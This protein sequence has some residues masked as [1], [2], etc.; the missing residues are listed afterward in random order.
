MPGLKKGCEKHP[1]TGRKKGGLNKR[2]EEA[3]ALAER[4]GFNP[5]ELLAHFAMGNWE[6]LG[7]P[8]PTKTIVT[9]E[10]SFEVD[11]I[12]EALR[13]KSAKDAIPFIYPQ[14]KSVEVAGD[15]NSFQSFAQMIAAL[16]KE[17]SGKAQT[18]DTEENIS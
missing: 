7:Y 11:R 16:V 4:L 8:G 2:T 3:R 14:L 13:Q 1:N 9:A 17:E 5:L 12:D 6:A 18:E 10:G 15:A